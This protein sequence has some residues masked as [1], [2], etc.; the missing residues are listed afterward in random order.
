MKKIVV[1]NQK[2]VLKKNDVLDFVSFFKNDDLCKDVVVCPSSLFLP[3]YENSNFIL[4]SQDVSLKDG[5]ATTGEVSSKQLKSMNVKYSIVGHSERREMFNDLST[6]IVEKINRLYDEDIIPILC[7]GEHLNERTS[8]SAKDVVARELMEVFDFN[9]KDKD[10]V[11]AYEPIWAIGTGLIPNNQDINEMISF[12]KDY[13]NDKYNKNV[14]VL[15]GG[16]VSLKN[17]DELNTVD[18]IDGYLIG[19]ASCKKEEFKEIIK[20]CI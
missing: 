9:V 2:T 6:T 5:G 14:K 11:I 8:G 19:G 4:G 13:L 20:K 18:I 17:I 1:G 3:Y 16:S 10:I 12:I 7:V 15:Y